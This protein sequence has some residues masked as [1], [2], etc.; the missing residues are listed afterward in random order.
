LQSH[1]QNNVA[2]FKQLLMLGALFL[3]ILTLFRAVLFFFYMPS[4]ET[5]YLGEIAAA[6]FLGL[7][8][9]LALSAYILALPTLFIMLNHLFFGIIPMHVIRKVLFFYYALILLLFSALLAADIGFYSYFQE[10]INI[11]IFGIMDDDTAALWSIAKSNYSLPAIFTA[12]ALY[13]AFIIWMVYRVLK[14]TPS[15]T[16]QLRPLWQPAA[17]LFAVLLIFVTARGSVGLFPLLKDIPDVSSDPLINTL[18]LNG[19]FAMQKATEQYVRSKSGSYDLIKDVGYKG[20]IDEAFRIYTGNGDLNDSNL[21]GSLYKK[22]K[23]NAYLS[24]HPP[25]VVVVMVE[26]FGTPILKYQSETFDIMRRLKKHFDKDILFTNFISTA[27][28]T[29]SSLEPLLLNTVARPQSTAFG[30]SGYLGVAFRQAAAKVYRENGYETTFVYGGDLSWRNVGSFFSRQ[31]F[32]HVEGKS[33][34]IKS[35]PETVQHDWGVY[36]QYAYDYVVKKLEA[37][38]KPQFVFL[39]TT[40]NHPPYIVPAS[41]ASKPLE[42]P[43]SLEEHITGDLAL[44]K[45]RLQDYQYALDMAGRFLDRVKESP[46]GEKT[47][48]ALT[49]DNNTIEG[50]MHYDDFYRT[51]KQ[52]PFYLYLPEAFRVTPPDT[53][54]SGSHKDIFPTLY[55]RTLSNASYLAIGSDLYD[56]GRLHCGFNESGI[57]LSSEGAFMKDKVQ[58]EGQQACN[59]QYN[60]ALAVTEYLVKSQ[61]K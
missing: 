42:M 61:K 20:R 33:S 15:A 48:V 29:V 45:Q 38:T 32:D 54:V 46:L 4:Y 11:M 27:N 58:S 19:V 30:Q 17:Y 14:K 59:E 37:A 31:G 5:H 60:A 1:F 50:V 25:H 12:G 26:S 36:D 16:L 2:L 18:P 10:H 8:I 9:D 39:L 7:R 22:T 28:G 40:N 21:I 52:I 49:A 35:I 41:Y 47:A 51:S 43:K 13:A 24:E 3:L 6:F 34:I 56:L 23:T 53:S 44:V 55:N 57:I